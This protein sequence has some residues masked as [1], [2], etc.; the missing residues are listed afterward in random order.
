MRKK[1]R[2][3]AYDHRDAESFFV[4]WVAFIDKNNTIPLSGLQ[5]L[6]GDGSTLRSHEGVC[7]LWL[8][9][10]IQGKLSKKNHKKRKVF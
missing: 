6:E 4:S 8:H 5:I 10:P 2:H 3:S 9:D 1:T 7:R